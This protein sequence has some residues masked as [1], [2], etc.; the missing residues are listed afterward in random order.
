MQVELLNRHP[1]P[2][3][4]ELAI[5]IAAAGSALSAHLTAKWSPA[6]AGYVQ[7]TI[8]RPDV[9]STLTWAFTMISGLICYVGTAGFEPATP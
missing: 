4:L 2:T 8:F 9:T 3:N 5:A 1:W 6:P 7:R